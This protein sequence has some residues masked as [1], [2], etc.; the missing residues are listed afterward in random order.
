MCPTPPPPPAP[1]CKPLP[2]TPRK[3][4]STLGATEHQSY[5]RRGR[6]RS[7]IPKGVTAHCCHHSPVHGKNGG[8]GVPASSPQCHMARV[9]PEA[10]T[11]GVLCPASP[12]RA[13][14]QGACLLLRGSQQDQSAQIKPGGAWNGLYPNPFDQISI[15]IFLYSKRAIMHLGD[16]EAAAPK[17]CKVP[18]GGEGRGPISQ[19]KSFPS[20]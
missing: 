13:K 6:L 11:H 9:K 14:A 18:P 3:L 20:N 10:Q 19:R 12:G 4:N 7:R 16:F 5:L 8:G 2:T 1:K 15:K 17:K